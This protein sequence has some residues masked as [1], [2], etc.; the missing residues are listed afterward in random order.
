MELILKETIDTLGEEGDIVRVKPGY[1]RNYLLPRNKAVAATP[2]N[3]AV[4][5][6][7]KAAIEARKKRLRTEAEDLAKAL[8]G[9]TITISQR[10]GE[11]NRLY[12]SVTAADIADRLAEMGLAIDRKKI[13]LT[14]PLKTLGVFTVPV[15]VS[16]QVSTEIKVQVEPLAQ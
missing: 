4:L 16:Y 10:V 12:G 1:A 13:L 6:Q 11:E 14:E 8:A 5:K 9:A 3:M 15:K 7:E 2:S